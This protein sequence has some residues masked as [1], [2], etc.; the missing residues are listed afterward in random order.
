MPLCP[1]FLDAHKKRGRDKPQGPHSH[2]LL[3]GGSEGFFWS[4]V[5]AKRDFFGSMK[6]VHGDLLGYC[7]F[8]QLKS[9]RKHKRNLLLVWDFFGY[10]KKCRVLLG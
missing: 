6:D 8:H 9:T 3:T 4:E 1:T 2:I 7:T 5:L 10:A